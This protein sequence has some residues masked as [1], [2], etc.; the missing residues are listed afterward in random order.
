MYNILLIGIS[1]SGPTSFLEITDA[2]L[3]YETGYP[4]LLNSNSVP[5]PIL[6]NNQSIQIPITENI[7]NGNPPVYEGTITAQWNDLNPSVPEPPTGLYLA[8]ALPLLALGDW[9]RR[10]KA[11]H[12]V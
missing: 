8:L 5:C 1:G 9:M 7:P 4:C 10:R 6:A 12:S 3:D 11:P 2:P